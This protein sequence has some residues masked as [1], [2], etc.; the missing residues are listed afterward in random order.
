MSKPIS[1]TMTAKN[2]MAAAKGPDPTCVRSFL[3][4]SSVSIRLRPIVRAFDDSDSQ[5]SYGRK[6]AFT[7]CEQNFE[8]DYRDTDSAAS[9]ARASAPGI[10]L[11]TSGTGSWLCLGCL[12]KSAEKAGL[13]LNCCSSGG[14]ARRRFRGHEYRRT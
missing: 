4:T 14:S 12:E 11:H 13:D 5:L 6:V 1:T 9:C 8:G 7:K 10:S 2:P 3:P